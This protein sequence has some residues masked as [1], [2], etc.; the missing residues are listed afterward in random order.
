M[1]HKYVNCDIRIALDFGGAQAGF[2]CTV[3]P[4]KD[5]DSEV[6]QKLAVWVPVGKVSVSPIDNKYNT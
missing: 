6:I 2:L 4:P 1:K 3:E 5:K